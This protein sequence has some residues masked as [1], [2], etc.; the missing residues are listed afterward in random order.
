MPIKS[1]NKDK[2][3]KNWKWYRA[4]ILHR[5][6]NKCEECGVDNGAHGHRDPSGRFW[7]M[8]EDFEWIHNNPPELHPDFGDAFKMIKIVLTVAHLDH[9]PTNNEFSN[10]KALCQKCHFGHDRK[11]NIKKARETRRKKE[12]SAGQKFLFEG[13]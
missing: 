5:A 13:E 4:A 12:E 2:Y 7:S 3:P 11:D 8:N 9:D 1:E 10:L 6:G